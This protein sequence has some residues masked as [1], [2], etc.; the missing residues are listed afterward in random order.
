MAGVDNENNSS[1]DWVRAYSP[2]AAYQDSG[3]TSYLTARGAKPADFG[4]FRASQYNSVTE[5]APKFTVIRMLNDV[6]PPDVATAIAVGHQ[7]MLYRGVLDGGIW[8][9]TP[10]TDENKDY[11]ANTV[12][13]V[14]VVNSTTAYACTGPSAA[15]G[16]SFHSNGGSILK[17]TNGGATWTAMRT[18]PYADMY[19]CPVPGDGLTQISF[20]DADHGWAVGKT[21]VG[22]AAAVVIKTDDGGNS[23]TDLKD[24]LPSGFTEARAV[25]AVDSTYAWVAGNTGLYQ[26]T[27]NGQTWT[28][29]SSQTSIRK[30]AMRNVQG[31]YKGWAIGPSGLLL[32]TINGADWHTET[33][34]A[35]SADF[36][37][38]WVSPDCSRATVA[39]GNGRFLTYNSS[40]DSWNVDAGDLSAVKES[41]CINGSGDILA[42][43]GKTLRGKASSGQWGDLYTIPDMNWRQRYL[44]C[45]LDGFPEDADQDGIPDDIKAMIDRSVASD[46]NGAGKFVLDWKVS[47]PNTIPRDNL[48]PLVGANNVVYNDTS[49]YL[50]R[51]QDVMGYSSPG[52]VHKPTANLVTTWGR[53]FNTWKPGGI[54]MF[55]TSFGAGDIREVAKVFGIERVYTGVEGNHL[56]FIFC[57]K[58]PDGSCAPAA[59]DAYNTHWVELYWIHTD[60]SE[61]TLLSQT[62][63]TEGVA[64]MNLG[65]LTWPQTGSVRARVQFP[66]G[67]PHV[68]EYLLG[69]VTQPLTSTDQ[70]NGAIFRLIV[71]AHPQ[72]SDLIREGAGGALGFVNE[73]FS[74]AMAE[75]HYMFPRYAA[76]FT[77]AEA[78]Y[79]GT[80]RLGA[81]QVVLGDP[82]MAPYATPPSVSII[83]PDESRI[84]GVIPIVVEAQ[85]NPPEVGLKRV[86]FWLTNGSGFAKRLG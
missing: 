77:W 19:L 6:Q 38:L 29:Q 44:V 35:G 57:G 33:H 66:N 37:D 73:P 47:E 4:E 81:Q 86:E 2:D 24:Y 63:N 18:A 64:D 22:T 70:Q 3:G 23:W 45:R 1:Y 69:S 40:E 67:D 61:E 36:R 17:T 85:S 12:S 76:G 48:I 27:S 21:A 34:S 68:G 49:T 54:G 56:K 31:Q 80:E 82:L 16:G 84:S 60:G 55:L 83:S 9:W 20:Y 5:A 32:H 71:F 74:Y 28:Q 15:Y 42:V 7:G 72:I 78:A 58:A 46:G 26:V 79:L 52:H 8:T 50:T 10:T 62:F 25:A 65:G 30:L 53:P 13:D 14:C 11:V 59:Y 43:C 39:Y 75:S 41:V 51:Q